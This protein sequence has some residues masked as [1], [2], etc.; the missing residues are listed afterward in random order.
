[1]DL[2]TIEWIIM[3]GILAVV[4]CVGVLNSRRGHVTGATQGASLFELSISTCVTFSS[5]VAMMGV[6]G[7]TFKI[8][9]RYGLIILSYPIFTFILCKW[10]VDKYRTADIKSVFDFIELKFDQKTKKI[11]LL[12][13]IL[14]EGF[15]ESQNNLSLR[16]AIYGPLGPQTH[17]PIFSDFS[18]SWIGTWSKKMNVVWVSQQLGPWTVWFWPM[19]P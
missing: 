17:F 4:I 2:A 14:Q 16:P 1:M 5:S 3:A 19:D 9:P 15:Q 7:E 12:I 6:P 13:Y 18:W 11:A 10:F 8:G